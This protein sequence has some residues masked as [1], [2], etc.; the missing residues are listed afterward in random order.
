MTAFPKDFAADAV[1]SDAQCRSVFSP[2][3]KEESVFLV[4]LS[5]DKKEHLRQACRCAHDACIGIVASKLRTMP[6]DCTELIFDE[7]S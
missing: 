3:T 1:D 4:K 5:M 7:N 6:L 2:L